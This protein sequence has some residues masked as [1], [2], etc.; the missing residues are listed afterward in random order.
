MKKHL[1]RY[2][3]F[4]F[5]LKCILRQQIFSYVLCDAD[6]GHKIFHRN[7]SHRKIESTVNKANVQLIVERKM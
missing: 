5:R 3:P 6:K 1:Q 7:Q 2:R 4:L